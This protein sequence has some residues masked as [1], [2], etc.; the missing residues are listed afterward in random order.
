MEPCNRQSFMTNFI[1]LYCSINEENIQRGYWQRSSQ[2]IILQ[3]KQDSWSILSR[4]AASQKTTP[5]A[6]LMDSGENETKYGLCIRSVWNLKR[7]MPG[8]RV[9]TVLGSGKSLTSSMWFQQ[10]Y[11]EMLPNTFPHVKLTVKNQNSFKFQTAT[12]GL[13]E[14]PLFD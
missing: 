5:T 8:P 7:R 2:R 12:K 10:G 4:L 9:R 6:A 13:S 11:F 14:T 1:Q 3:S